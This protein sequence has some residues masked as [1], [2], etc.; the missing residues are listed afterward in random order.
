MRFRLDESME[1]RLAGLLEQQGHDVKSVAQDY[2]HSLPDREVLALAVQEG[3]I[4]LT[5]DSDFG[6]LIFARRLPHRGV[7]YFRLPAAT[8]EMKFYR[9]QAV[10]SSHVEELEHFLVVTARSVRVRAASKP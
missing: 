4:L 9:L 3:R 2:R 10:L 1:Q 8:A 7:I 6:E 5:N